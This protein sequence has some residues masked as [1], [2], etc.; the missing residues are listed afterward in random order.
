MN[1][2]D[3][4]T[5]INNDD[6]VMYVKNII[7]YFLKESKNEEIEEIKKEIVGKKKDL[8]ACFATWSWYTFKK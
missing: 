5:L 8:F 2:Y 7:E 3:A 6:E 1:P 4:V